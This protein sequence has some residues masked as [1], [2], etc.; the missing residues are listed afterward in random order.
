[1]SE[2]R[3]LIAS[4]L[5]PVNDTRMYEKLGLSLS[6]LPGTAVH[7]CGFAAPLPAS[8]PTNLHFHPLFR[9]QRL[10]LGRL[11]AQAQYYR[12]LH[13]LKPDLII[14][15]THELLLPSYLY[16]RNRATK[17]VYDVQ[18]N[19]TLN[20]LK[21]NSYNSVLKRLLALGVGSIEKFVAPAI[22]RFILAEKCY[23]TELGFL[24]GRYMVLE[25]KYKKQPE[26]KAPLT[27]IALKDQPL[28]LLFSGT[29]SEEYGIMEAIALADKLYTLDRSISLTIIGYCAM[30]STWNRV[31]QAV[32]GKSYIS[33]FG[34]PELVPHT[35]IV[36]AMQRCNVGLLPYRPNESTFNCIPTKLYEYMAHGLVILISQNP[37]WQAIVQQHQAGIAIDFK[38]TAEK[39]LWMQ[40]RQQQFY[41]IGIP[42]TIFWNEEEA[43]LLSIVQDLLK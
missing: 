33:V 15:C 11:R 25:N 28:R 37:T 41:T 42:G 23:A 43:R 6:R 13:N 34:G 2:K 16:C 18:E 35:A 12:L 40:L 22:A 21:Q 30:G 5:K 32:K 19:Y 36:E 8:T 14:V 38:T 7:L 20:L 29:I 27:P 3:I 10:S 26:Y 4:L 9:F 24:Q 17:L 1:M 39:E 31:L